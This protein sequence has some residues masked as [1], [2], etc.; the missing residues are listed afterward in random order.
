MKGNFSSQGLKLDHNLPQYPRKK[1]YETLSC[2]ESVLKGSGGNPQGL[3]FV[4]VVANQAPLAL[5][6]PGA[7]GTFLAFALQIV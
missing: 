3:H 7:F 1:S 4:L 2:K 5:S 6:N